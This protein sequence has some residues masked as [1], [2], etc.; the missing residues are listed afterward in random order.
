LMM[1]PG[2]GVDTPPALEDAILS[3]FVAGPGPAGPDNV[4]EVCAEAKA[5]RLAKGIRSGLPV[6]TPKLHPVRKFITV[7]LADRLT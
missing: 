6:F 5:A 3:F 2:D 1:S 7:N 4:S